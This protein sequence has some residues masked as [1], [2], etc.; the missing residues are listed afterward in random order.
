MFTALHKKYDDDI[1]KYWE[2]QVLSKY[3]SNTY[4]TGMRRAYSTHTHP[5]L[6]LLVTYHLLVVE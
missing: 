5:R 3:T 6:P 4:S 2:A 1:K